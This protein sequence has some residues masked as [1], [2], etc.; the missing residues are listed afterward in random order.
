VD[1]FPRGKLS[2]FRPVCPHVN[3]RITTPFFI[4]FYEFYWLGYAVFGGSSFDCRSRSQ[5]DRGMKN[6]PPDSSVATVTMVELDVRARAAFNLIA[7]SEWDL[8]RL[9]HAM[10]KRGEW[11]QL[12]CSSVVDYAERRLGMPAD[13]L[14]SLLKLFT[15]VERFPQASEAWRSGDIGR[16]K[17]RDLLRVMTPS[18]EGRWLDFARK[19]TRAE[20]SSAR[21]RCG[22]GRPG[23]GVLLWWP[24]AAVPWLPTLRRLRKA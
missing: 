22:R 13:H 18:T 10:Q 14:F 4:D 24:K 21:S 20:S 12:G 1:N 19:S 15:D 17:L 7:H 11:Q 5:Y 8:A 2:T 9:L 3:T 6:F 23:C 16:A